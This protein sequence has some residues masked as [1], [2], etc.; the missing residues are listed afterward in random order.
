M[1]FRSEVRRIIDDCYG[2][3]RNLLQENRDKLDSMA[4]ALLEFETIDRTQIDDIMAGRKPQPPADWNDKDDHSASGTDTDTDADTDNGENE[5][6][7]PSGPV[8]G[9]ATEH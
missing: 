3:A 9:P 2:I 7:R 4:N 5:D 8:G 6:P 1:L